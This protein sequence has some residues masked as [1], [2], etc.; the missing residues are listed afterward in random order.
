[1]KLEVNLFYKRPPCYSQVVEIDE[2]NIIEAKLKA[3]DLVKKV[4]WYA[5]FKDKPK[6]VAVNQIF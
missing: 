3:T 5:G 6:K 2:P 4:A 1:M